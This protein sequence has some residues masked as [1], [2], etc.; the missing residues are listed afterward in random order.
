MRTLLFSF[1][2]LSM[3]LNTTKAAEKIVST[4]G[5]ASEIVAAL[6]KADKLVGVD[7]TSVKPQTIMEKKPKIGYRRQLS[8]EGILSLTP[9]LII[10]APDAGPN[11]VIEQIKASGIPL[12]HLG[13]KPSLAGIREDI[14]QIAK[15][16][17]AESEAKQL[18]ET[19][20]ADEKN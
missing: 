19:I 17:G 2:A 6:G 9:D 3:C 13:E 7:T 15:A 18:T 10:L 20:L 12:L 16:I 11:A 14:Q 1:I 8:A 4:A 5:Y